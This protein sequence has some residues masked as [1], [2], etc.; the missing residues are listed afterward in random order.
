[1][2]L[3]MQCML[4]LGV[5]A[6][7]QPPAKPVDPAT[8][9]VVQTFDFYEVVP[10]DAKQP[11]TL[12]QAIAQALVNHPDMRLAEAELRVAEAKLAQSRIMVSQKVTEA[13]HQLEK[14][15]ADVE[16]AK[17][18]WER[19]TKLLKNSA[20]SQEEYRVVQ[21]QLASAKARLATTE[22][23]WKLMMGSP[24]NRIG[25]S[26]AINNYLE[27]RWARVAPNTTDEITYTLLPYFNVTQ[28]PALEI[29]RAVPD[30]SDT[31]TKDIQEQLKA[32]LGTRVKLDKQTNI[33]MEQAFQKVTEG[34][35]LKV[36]VKL[37]VTENKTMYKNITRINLD[38][39]E[40]PLHTWL[41]L[42][43]D[44]MNSY[45]VDP[46]TRGQEGVKGYVLYV[47][48]YGLLLTTR[49]LAPPDAI[50]V[51]NLWK[52]SQFEKAADAAK[53]SQENA[54]PKK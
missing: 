51:Q 12:D 16:L 3:L 8:G 1:M 24:T 18:N 4:M 53:K 52:Q 39:S 33:D 14:E 23:A 27:Y 26:P 35:G 46:G 48:E 9:K 22:S 20:I 45:Q 43:V 7:V 49:D 36:R 44:E 54:V 34:A 37:P 47:R 13:F 50:T 11:A 38:A 40:F 31:G 19:M 6:P 25:A 30:K 2:N 21:H 17:A 32:K 28:N 10:V 41:Q 5:Y 29:Y 42:I 15:R